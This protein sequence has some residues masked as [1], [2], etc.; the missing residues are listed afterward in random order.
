MRKKIT[1]IALAIVNMLFINALSEAQSSRKFIG[2]NVSGKVVSSINQSNSIA[3]ATVKVFNKSTVTG[4]YE[5]VKKVTTDANGQ[6]NFGKISFAQG[7]KPRIGAYVNDIIEND[8]SSEEPMLTDEMNEIGAYANDLT[9]DYIQI[10]DP[11]VRITS[12]LELVNTTSLNLDVLVVE[13]DGGIGTYP[14]IPPQQPVTTYALK[15]NFPNPFNPVTNISFSLPEA[16][17]VTLDVYDMSGKLVEQLVNETKSKG[18]HTVQF[19][20]TQ[21]AS[22]FYIY[23]LTTP[24]FSEI[25]KMSLVK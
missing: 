8:M 23:K 21:L 15:Q 16:S 13:F 24:D 12:P 19:D 3:N 4:R 20:G 11:V 17:F 25:K 18:L 22:G 5:L 1:I 7:D 14:R 9:E 2:I 6:Y 10:V